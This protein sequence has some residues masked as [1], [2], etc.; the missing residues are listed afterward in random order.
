M[1]EAFKGDPLGS[2]RFFAKWP[3]A[4][5]CAEVW[6][7]QPSMHTLLAIS[8]IAQGLAAGGDNLPAALMVDTLRWPAD[9]AAL[10]DGLKSMALCTHTDPSRPRRLADVGAALDGIEDKHLVAA[11]QSVTSKW[12]IESA[13]RSSAALSSGSRVVGKAAGCLWPSGLPAATDVQEAQAHPTEV[14]IAAVAQ[15]PDVQVDRPNAT[16][17][18]AKPA[19]AS[20]PPPPPPPQPASPI[21]DPFADLRIQFPPPAP[22][23]MQV[24][25][26]ELKLSPA[27]SQQTSVVK[28]LSP[29]GLTDREGRWHWWLALAKVGL[30]VKDMYANTQ[31]AQY[32][33]CDA[34]AGSMG[35]AVVKTGGIGT[36]LWMST[37]RV[38]SPNATA[39]LEQLLRIA[40]PPFHAASET[41]GVLM[42]RMPVTGISLPATLDFSTGK[43]Q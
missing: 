4:A 38:Y 35:Q 26:Q 33:N 9:G 36:I 43:F 22:T 39:H 40:F 23:E 19:T 41:S 1:L 42:G 25:F 24:Q 16:T 30:F 10:R 37:G 28:F 21:E 31:H 34:G 11:V 3:A 20:P 32:G 2:A 7:R 8:A 5:E 27:S 14:S 6:A 12:K 29:T 18:Q 13:T 17:A 15:P